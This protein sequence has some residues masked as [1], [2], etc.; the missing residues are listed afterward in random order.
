MTII[1]I[2]I[3]TSSWW[4]HHDVNKCHHM[5]SIMSSSLMTSSL[6]T[7]SWRHP[8]SSIISSSWWH[9]HDVIRCHHMTPSFRHHHSD[10]SHQKHALILL[11]WFSCKQRSASIWTQELANA[12]WKVFWHIREGNVLKYFART[13]PE[14]SVAGKRDAYSQLKQPAFNILY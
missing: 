5:T 7:S 1:I 10:M 6:M 3:V 2:M 9:H 14:F 4:H 12:I 13:P 11:P 8:M